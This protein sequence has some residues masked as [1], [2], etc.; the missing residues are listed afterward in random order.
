M[1]A[2]STLVHDEATNATVGWTLLGVVALTAVSSAIG[3][4]FLRAAFASLV[5]AVAALPALVRA[6]REV[7]VPWPLLALTTGAVV[8]LT[9]GG[10]PEIGTPV[11]VSGLALIGVAELDAFTPVEMSHRFAVGFAA[12]TTLALQGV[13]IV[14]QFYADLFLG[15]DYLTTQVELQMDIVVVTVTALAV[16]LLFQWYVGRFEPPGSRAYHGGSTE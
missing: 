5:V 4:E 11:A 15:T 8:T 6:D 1:P 16:G 9:L 13:W 14:A 12:L 3:G 7:M 2:A 10:R